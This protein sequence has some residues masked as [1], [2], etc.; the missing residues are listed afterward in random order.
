MN[1][2]QLSQLIDQKSNLPWREIST[3]EI[4]SQIFTTL[5][6]CDIENIVNE[7]TQKNDL[8]TLKAII[9]QIGLQYIT[10]L[11]DS[12][13]SDIQWIAIESLH[14]NNHFRE[15]LINNPNVDEYKKTYIKSIYFNLTSEEINNIL[16]IIPNNKRNIA[17][18]V[19][20]LLNQENITDTQIEK[21][22]NLFPN[23][24]SIYYFSS[25]TPKSV[26][27]KIAQ[28]FNCSV[29]YH[30]PQDKAFHLFN[31]NNSDEE[32]CLAILNSE[33]V[34]KLSEVAWL[35][36]SI[37]RPFK[38]FSEQKWYKKCIEKLKQ[39]CPHIF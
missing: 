2:E 7:V 10:K 32:V 35:T 5:N 11:I 3:E 24:E 25:K 39:L 36:T 6:S 1:I 27:L 30:F 13:N 33:A 22:Y 8:A 23:E 26:L 18:I 20:Y 14:W 29:Y 9:K 37:F 19:K 38:I 17:I 28:N 4:I 16:N 21:I 34:N 15:L 31:H 12:G